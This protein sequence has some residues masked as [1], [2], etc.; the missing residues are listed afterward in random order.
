MKLFC[1]VLSWICGSALL[2]FG[3]VGLFIPSSLIIPLPFIVII[4]MSFLLLP[5]V[6]KL[7]YS[8]TK[9][10]LSI[11]ERTSYMI[12]LFVA[13]FILVLI[14]D[15]E[16]DLPPEAKTETLNKEALIEYYIANKDNIIQ[17]LEKAIDANDAPLVSEFSKYSVANDDELNAL[18]KRAETVLK[19][20]VEKESAVVTERRTRIERQ[21]ST[22]DGSHRGL[23]RLIKGAMKDPDSYEHDETV[24]WD[25]GDS[26]IVKIV[27]RGKN[28][29]GSIVTS[30]V[31]AE[32]SLDGKILK[33]LEQS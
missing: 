21:F 16:S 13:F 24:Y 8:K 28:S 5:P 33:I 2:L 29:V 22:W 26:L 19:G 25:K 15:I 11:K 6:R 18:L 1:L 4:A 20:K 31:K 10:K 23:E 27:Y 12:A 7:V 9:K 17:S 32:I 3:V 14:T 30:F